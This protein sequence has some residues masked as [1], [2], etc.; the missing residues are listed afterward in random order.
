MIVKPKGFEDPVNI[1]DDVEG[2]L[3]DSTGT[4]WV[5][6]PQYDEEGKSAAFSPNTDGV[7]PRVIHLDREQ[8]KRACQGKKALLEPITVEE[9]R[10]LADLNRNQWGCAV[11]E[12][13]NQQI[14]EI[15]I[16]ADESGKSVADL[17][18]RKARVQLSVARAIQEEKES[19]G[20]ATEKPEE[21]YVDTAPTKTPPHHKTQ[22][23][24]QRAPFGAITLTARQV[25]FLQGRP[26]KE[27][28]TAEDA[29]EGFSKMTVGAMISTLREKGVI[30]TGKAT[31]DKGKR[32][33]IFQLTD[34]GKQTLEHIKQEE[35]K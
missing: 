17:I 5:R 26:D 33:T 32:V 21:A 31:T 12:W 7:N 20:E 14:R 13:N 10:A 30:S 24:A 18:E 15:M 11:D 8:L 29:P 6:N 4:R 16:E 28:F 27:E 19:H 3:V 25:E 34:M 22:E 35:S 2:V 1:V 23:K 9:V